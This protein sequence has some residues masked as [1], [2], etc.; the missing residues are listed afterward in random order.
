[1]KKDGRWIVQYR[2]KKTEK[3]K[4]EYFGRGLEAEQKAK[5]RNKALGLRSWKRR[6][7]KRESPFFYELWDA[8]IEA[9]A[10]KI[11][12]T[13]VDNMLI[14]MR[15]IILPEIALIQ[16]I[17]LTD[18]RMDQY[19][20]KRLKKVKRTTVHREL[21]DIQA[22]LNWSVKRKFLAFNPIQHYEKPDRDD[23]PIR[24]PSP[25][26]TRKILE[27]ASPHLIRAICLSHYTGI[28]PGAR[29]LF[30]RTWDDV[31]FDNKTIFVIS[32]RKGGRLKSRNVPLHPDLLNLLYIWHY[33]DR[34]FA[35]KKKKFPKA[36]IHFRGKAIKKIKT[37]FRNAKEKAGITRR[38]R[39]YDFRHSFATNVLKEK[40]DLKST[41]EILGHSRTE[42]TTRIYQHTDLE[43]HRDAIN[44][45]PSLID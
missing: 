30:S 43:M 7:P 3:L 38:I 21:S 9:K 42:T 10:K 12:E 16:A 35:Y 5:E 19:V 26:E 33:E 22:I 34:K 17:N 1:M 18:H 13:T 40:G 8:Y 29:E 41:S 44:K 2:D 20:N 14:K 45:V 4:T 37:A 27:H 39:F 6:T 25:S 23:E 15:K 24:P 11:G 36:I 31:D 28:R 32:A